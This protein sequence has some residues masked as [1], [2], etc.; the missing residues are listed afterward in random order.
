MLLQFAWQDLRT[1]LFEFDASH[2]FD[3]IIPYMFEYVF[4]GNSGY[5]RI[6]HQDCWL[7]QMDLCLDLELSMGN[8]SKKLSL[9]FN[10][11]K[12]RSRFARWILSR[13]WSPTRLHIT[14]VI[15]SWIW[16]VHNYVWTME[17]YLVQWDLD[18]IRPGLWVNNATNVLSWRHTPKEYYDGKSQSVV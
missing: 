13:K 14:V 17:I 8:Y 15:I 7:M 6:I 9:K 5:C 3:R 1:D 11:N 18:P 16:K 12:N 10:P 2:G 4:F